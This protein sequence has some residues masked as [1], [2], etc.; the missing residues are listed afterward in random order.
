MTI[1]YHGGPIWGGDEIIKACYRDGGAL[2][3]FARTEQIKKIALVKCDLVLDNGAFSTWNNAKKK[4]LIVDWDSHWSG[5]Y[6]FVGSWISRIEWFLI[7]DVIGGD[8][9]ENDRLIESVPSWLA[10]KAVPVWHSE[11]SIERFVSLCERF[12][13]VAIGCMGKH[14]SIRSSS[15]VK[16]MNE[17]FS[18][19]YI[20]RNISVKIHGLRMLDGRAL[21]QFPFDSAD[22][23]N[24][25]I[26]VPKDRVRF[27]EVKDKLARTAILRAAI[28]KV[29][30]PTINEW[31]KSRN[32]EGNECQLAFFE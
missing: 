24:V 26:N 4:D 7:P 18:S 23:T 27:P 11:S 31:I 20:E 17:A 19:I 29:K 22:S 1:H 32:S 9:G 5:Y 13:R 15:W 8:D 30:P 16:R 10:H 28:E 25:A 3:S 2:V 14:R 6:D 12:D 21:S